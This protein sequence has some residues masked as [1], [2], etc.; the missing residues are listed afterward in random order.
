MK[1]RGNTVGT[2]VKRPDWNETDPLKSDYIRNKP[3]IEQIVSS[4]TVKV[5]IRET[6]PEVRPAF[7]FHTDGQSGNG[8]AVLTYIDEAGNKFPVYPVTRVEAVE[9]LDALKKTAVVTLPASSWSDNAQTVSAA[10]VTEDNTV[11][12]SPAPGSFAAYGEAA[13]Y[14]DSQGAGQL[15]FRCTDVPSEDLTVNVLI[16]E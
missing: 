11:I 2:T 9:G 1:I 10:G 14:C 5:A 13:V 16:L 3:D 12:V 15:T 4:K 7:W 8:A 6:E